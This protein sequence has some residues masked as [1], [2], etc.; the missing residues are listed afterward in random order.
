MKVIY[1]NADLTMYVVRGDS[2]YPVV[3]G[4]LDTFENDAYD[5]SDAVQSAL[6]T[7]TAGCYTVVEIGGFKYVA[8]REGVEVTLAQ[9]LQFDGHEHADRYLGEA[10]DTVLKYEEAS[11]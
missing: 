10:L 11:E 8:K 1:F 4:S 6:H 5:A 9:V 2:T 3:L 7:L